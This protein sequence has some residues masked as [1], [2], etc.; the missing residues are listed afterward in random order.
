MQRSESGFYLRKKTAQWWATQVLRKNSRRS[1][2]DVG[3]L[4][5]IKFDNKTVEDVGND[6]GL[7]LK[8]NQDIRQSSKDWTRVLCWH[9]HDGYKD[10]C[11]DSECWTTY[12]DPT[13]AHTHTHTVSMVNL[14]TIDTTIVG[15]TEREVHSCVCPRPYVYK[16]WASTTPLSKWS[17]LQRR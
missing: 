14:V 17:W 4:K 1:G 15:Q 10:T 12:R 6:R 7:G 5:L 16:C 13:T 11:S 3:D 8:W 2:V 9:L